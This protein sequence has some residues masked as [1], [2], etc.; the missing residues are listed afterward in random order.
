MSLLSRLIER[1]RGTTAAPLS[2]GDRWYTYEQPRNLKKIRIYNASERT[3][4]LEMN[5]AG[6]IFALVA[7]FAGEENDKTKLE[8]GDFVYRLLSLEER[9]KLVDHWLKATKKANRSSGFRMK[10]DHELRRKR[11]VELSKECGV[12]QI[13]P[14]E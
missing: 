11:H 5:M 1:A 9:T 14:I 2:P 3:M 6:E 10:S 7:P 12:F 4:P 8:T 13:Q